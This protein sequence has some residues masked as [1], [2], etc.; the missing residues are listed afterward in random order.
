MAT[1]TITIDLEAYDQL[2]ALRSGDE[3]FSQV[4]HRVV[5]K[6]MDIE[7]FRRELKEAKL[8]DATISAVE[9]QI[10]ARHRPSRRR[11]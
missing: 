4:I 7:R 2:K 6:P 10:A 11:R 1:K 9:E 3:S 5:P 8:S